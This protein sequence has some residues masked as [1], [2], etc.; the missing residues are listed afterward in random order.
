MRGRT[1]EVGG[2]LS[3]TSIRNTVIDNRVVIPM[4]TCTEY[5]YKYYGKCIIPYL[6]FTVS[7]IT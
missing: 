6:L 3:A 5:M 2:I 1:S 7:T 4:V